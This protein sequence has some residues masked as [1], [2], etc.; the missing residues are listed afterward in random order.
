M[1][2]LHLQDAWME[3]SPQ[4]F[5]IFGLKYGVE[6]TYFVDDPI[7][8]K[9]SM[10]LEKVIFVNTR[11]TTWDAM[12]IPPWWC[13][14]ICEVIVMRFIHEVG[15]VYRGHSGDLTLVLTPNGLHIPRSQDLFKDV[16]GGNEGEAWEF[17]LS[18]RKKHCDEF[19]RLYLSYKNWYFNHEFKYKDW[20]NDGES[21]WRR[22]NNRELSQESFRSIPGWVKEKFYKYKPD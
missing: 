18:I 22:I 15:H 6:D 17:A 14:D 5:I 16:L 8:C 19:S 7:K 13:K 4:E 20:D 9:N 21:Q 10:R 1:R 12:I 11:G 2:P 3:R